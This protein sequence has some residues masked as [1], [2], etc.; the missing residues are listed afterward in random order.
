MS[1]EADDSSLGRMEEGGTLA[2]EGSGSS[3]T[4]R[5]TDPNR[6]RLSFFGNPCRSILSFVLIV[7]SHCT[8]AY[9]IFVIF[10]NFNSPGK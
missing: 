3:G 7:S 5:Y 6:L 2:L 10:R 8:V 4:W 9:Y 1:S